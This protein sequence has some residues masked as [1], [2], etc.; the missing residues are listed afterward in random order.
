[1]TRRHLVITVGGAGLGAFVVMG[2]WLYTSIAT[3]AYVTA[4]TARAA[5]AETMAARTQLAALR[6]QLNPHFLFNALHS[7]VQL[8]PRDPAR[9][10]S[11][12]EEV[13]GLLRATIEEHRDVVTLEEELAFVRRYLGV[14][15]MRFGDRLVVEEST[16]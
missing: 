8:I 2:I 5:Y 6:A 4:A 13:A 12:A 16:S 14:E 15:R 9:A 10:A 11:A 3:V 7:V 1:M